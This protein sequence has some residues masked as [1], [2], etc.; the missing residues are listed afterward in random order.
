M[1]SHEMRPLRVSNMSSLAVVRGL[2]QRLMQA[3]VDDE[4][5]RK[6]KL[7][8]RKGKILKTRNYSDEDDDDPD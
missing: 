6:S 8:I 5:H 7:K 1:R 4:D 2:V 3:D